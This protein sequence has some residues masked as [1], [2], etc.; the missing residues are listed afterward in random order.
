MHMPM[1]V[2]EAE[3]FNM[4]ALHVFLI[5][6]VYMICIPMCV[7]MYVQEAEEFKL[8]IFDESRTSAANASSTASSAGSEDGGMVQTIV[9]DQPQGRLYVCLIRI[10]YLSPYVYAL[11]VSL[12]HM[13]SRVHVCMPYMYGLCACDRECDARC[14][15]GGRRPCVRWQRS[16]TTTPP[17]RSNT[18]RTIS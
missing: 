16:S 8:S 9:F 17:R 2:Q 10:P 3:E 5:C 7:S 12:G 18:T 13:P 14:E 1:Y 6:L 15:Q 4:S 11:D